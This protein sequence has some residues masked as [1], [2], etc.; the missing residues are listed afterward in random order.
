M[1]RQPTDD[2]PIPFS[3]LNM[4][5]TAWTPPAQQARLCDVSETHLLLVK[6]QISACMDAKAP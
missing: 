6:L 4:S 5:N 2:E 3:F 1:E